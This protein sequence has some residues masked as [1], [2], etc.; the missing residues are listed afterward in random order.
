MPHTWNELK[1]Q[2]PGRGVQNFI[3]MYIRSFNQVGRIT[4]MPS[5]EGACH[6]QIYDTEKQRTLSAN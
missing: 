5:P 1:D 3:F 4:D 6:C 2:E